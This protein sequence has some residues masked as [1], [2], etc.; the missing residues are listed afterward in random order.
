MNKVNN[1]L[2][3]PTSLDGNFFK[4]WIEVLRPLHKL[5]NRE[6]DVIASF[7]KHRYTLSKAISDAAILDRI[8]LSKDTQKEVIKD[9]GITLQYL[10]TTMSKFRKNGVIVNGRINPKF[11]PNINDKGMITLLVCFDL[12]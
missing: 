12:K 5:T 8:T 2:R 11:I 6:I 1:A 7:I 4:L 9:C 3:L 10:Q